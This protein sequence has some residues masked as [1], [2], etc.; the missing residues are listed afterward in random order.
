[1]S[2]KVSDHVWKHSRAKTNAALLV[3][4][5]LADYANHEGIAWPALAKIAKK[6]RLR[7][8]SVC[9]A[10]TDLEAMGEWRR[11]R[12]SGGARK[13]TKYTFTLSKNSDT[14][15][16]LNGNRTLTQLHTK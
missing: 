12:S 9:R 16:P 3:S 15:S 6:T 10:I 2:V 8:R 4:L 5:A 14:A 11:E 7:V 1:M 13:R